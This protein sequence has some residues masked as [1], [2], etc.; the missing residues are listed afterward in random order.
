MC[1]LPVIVYCFDTK[2][3]VNGFF[4]KGSGVLCD[5]INRYFT[6][7]PVQRTPWLF[8]KFHSLVLLGLTPSLIGYS[9]SPISRYYAA[10][11]PER[12]FLPPYPSFPSI[13]KADSF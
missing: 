10:L 11:T 13:Y 5:R 9:L 7:T 4:L 8:L 2:N 12:R 6:S 1:I 3:R